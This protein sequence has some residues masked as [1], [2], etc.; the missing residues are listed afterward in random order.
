M[1]PI[2]ATIMD[3][4][5]ETPSVRTFVFDVDLGYVPGQYVMTWV[6]GVDEVPMSLSYSD[7]ITVQRVGDA[8]TAMFNLGE[9]DSLGLR[10]PYGEG[11]TPR[12]KILIIAGGVGAAPL[13]GLA[14]EADE[15]LTLLGAKTAS[16]LVFEDRFTDAGEVRVATDDGTKGYHGFVTDLL[17]DVNMEDY[18]GVAVTG[19]ELMMRKVLEVAEARG[20]ERWAEFSLHRYFKCGVGV[21]GSCCTDPQGLRVCADGPVFTGDQ[22]INSEFGE[23][24]RDA[25]GR[26][27]PL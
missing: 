4:V 25:S 15:A 12:D 9:G 18:E 22:L 6:R 27:T 2:N 5:E 17:D 21:C 26:K 3:I 24:R 7:A 13:A 1:K 10:G 23:Y 14:E 8:T 16:E 11:F 20:V 19:P